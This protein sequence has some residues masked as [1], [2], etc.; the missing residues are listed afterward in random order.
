MDALVKTVVV[1]AVVMLASYY[2]IAGIAAYKAVKT[3]EPTCESYWTYCTDK[4][5]DDAM[6]GN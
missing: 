6:E 4:G 1:L 2:V 5:F 3:I